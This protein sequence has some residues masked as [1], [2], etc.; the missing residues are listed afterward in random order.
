MKNWLT[1]FNADKKFLEIVFDFK[2]IQ[3]SMA[4][5]AN[6]YKVIHFGVDKKYGTK[7][8]NLLE[9]NGFKFDKPIFEIDPELKSKIINFLILSL[10]I[11][12]VCN[13]Q[14]TFSV[15]IIKRSR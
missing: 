11:K 9:N 12:V 14:N 10:F 4:H 13:F 3:F 8:E 5:I 2:N 1:I 15:S 7:I 6:D